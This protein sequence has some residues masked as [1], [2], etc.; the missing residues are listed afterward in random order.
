M[1]KQ[2]LAALMAFNFYAFSSEP[3]LKETTERI[4]AFLLQAQENKVLEISLINNEICFETKNSALFSKKEK[5]CLDSET[6][7]KLWKIFA[8][9]NNLPESSFST[10]EEFQKKLSSLN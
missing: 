2:L 3:D 7:Y 6:L 8:V 10:K 4:Q 1:K 5:E 9:A